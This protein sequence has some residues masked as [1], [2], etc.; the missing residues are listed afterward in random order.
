MDYDDKQR[1]CQDPQRLSGRDTKSVCD[2]PNLI[3]KLGEGNNKTFRQLKKLVS[4]LRLK[5]TDSR[6]TE[7]E[8]TR[9]RLLSTMSQVN[10]TGG[11]NGRVIAVLKSDLIDFKLPLAA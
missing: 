10:C 2:S 3:E 5:V 1:L 11:S 9:D 7:D 6:Q 4:K 8:L